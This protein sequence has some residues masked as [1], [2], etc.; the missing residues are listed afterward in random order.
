MQKILASVLG[1]LAGL[2]SLLVFGWGVYSAMSV[3]FGENPALTI[4]Y[5]ALPIVSLPVCFLALAFQR[6]A[7]V[8]AIL[9]IAW[10]PVY[11]ALNR[12]SCS[13]LGVCGSIASTVLMT[14]T[15]RVMLEYLA[16]AACLLAAARLR[17]RA[18]RNH[19][20]NDMRQQSN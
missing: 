1:V 8:Q 18:Q 19:K 10:L 13:A 20:A 6:L 4:L 11:T 16:S 15:T 12:R 14:L 2:L 7:V 9:A 5:C 17:N 3:D